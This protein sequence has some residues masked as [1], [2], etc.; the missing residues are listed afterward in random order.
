MVIMLA[1]ETA[2]EEHA[3]EDPNTLVFFL[4]NFTWYIKS[5]FYI[6]P[7]PKMQDLSFIFFIIKKDMQLISVHQLIV[8]LLF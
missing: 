3:A 6:K 7:R 4:P 1:A 5:M 2:A 8:V